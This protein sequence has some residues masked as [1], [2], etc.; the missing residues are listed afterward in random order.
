M[1]NFL[2]KGTKPTSEIMALRKAAF[3]VLLTT[4]WRISKLHA[5]VRENEFCR[6]SENSTLIMRPHL[7]FLA[8]N[9]GKE[10]GI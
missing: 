6:F 9:E 4:G 7:T 8:K 2:E 5:C 1:L 3:L 10:N